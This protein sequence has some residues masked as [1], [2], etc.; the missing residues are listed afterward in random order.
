[1]TRQNTK[2]EGGKKRRRSAGAQ[3]DE[4]QGS[5]V[6]G[7]VRVTGRDDKKK[8]ASISG[9][10]IRLEEL[11]DGV[12]AYKKNGAGPPKFLFYATQK[13]RWKISDVLGDPKKGFAYLT[14]NDDGQSGPYSSLWTGLWKIFD[15]KDSGY[16]IDASVSCAL[17]EDH[18]AQTT[19]NKSSTQLEQGGMKN[20]SSA[21]TS[22]ETDSD[23]SDSDSDVS[24]DVLPADITG[25]TGAYGLLQRTYR[26]KPFQGQYCFLNGCAV[27]QQGYNIAP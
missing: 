15:S 3:E 27:I 2:K 13:R 21:S 6:Q 8:N 26:P 24:Q 5:Q 9:A 4:L 12:P 25:T 11:V 10:Y 14:V 22:S 18:S 20:V 1:M 17:I 19:Q 23:D 7:A 16:T